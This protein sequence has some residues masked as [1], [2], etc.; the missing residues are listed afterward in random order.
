MN[1]AGTLVFKDAQAAQS[2]AAN[3]SQLQQTIQ[4]YS[5]FMALAGIGNPIH[6]LQA[7]P[8]GS[9]AQFVL[10]LE[11]KGV[12]WLMNQLANQLGAPVQTIS[13]ST[14]PAVQ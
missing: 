1:F 4:S 12:E 6:S 3:I 8:V 14:A 2:A 9:D 7:T 11:S 5:F 10:S 13:A